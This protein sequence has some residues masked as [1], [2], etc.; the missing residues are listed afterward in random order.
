MELK[1][2]VSAPALNMEADY[3]ADGSILVVPIKGTGRCEIK[4][5]MSFCPSLLF[6]N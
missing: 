5:S 2:K 1:A 6:I 4:M 3:E